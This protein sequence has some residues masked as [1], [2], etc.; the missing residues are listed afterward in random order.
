MTPIQFVFDAIGT[1]WAI[2]ILTPLSIN[3]QSITL[4]KI[5]NRIEIF[6][7]TYSRFRDDSLI[8]EISIE[9][10]AYGFPKDA[11]E[12]FSFY[13]KMY[14]ISDG[15]VTPLIGKTLSDA[16]YDTD[17]SL[18]PKNIHKPPKW[19]DVLSYNHPVL[20]VK[21]PVLL[22]F[23]AA[24]KGYIIDIVAK[25]LERAKIY[26][27][28]ID[29]GGDILLRNSDSQSLRVGLEHPM[30]PKKV[31]GTVTIK[32]QS[33][34]GSSGNR[35]N[36]G[37]YHHIINPYTLSSPKNIL[38]TWTIADSAILADGMTTCL[39][40]ISGNVLQS[41]FD[42]EYF[43]LF[44]DYSYEKSS[45]FSAEVYTNVGVIAN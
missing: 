19:G 12:L 13:K 22:D 28:C 10:G 9:K 40:F 30:N 42:F 36:W 16:G 7:K 26:D 38:S 5:K 43:V 4:K 3:E 8:T 24:G 25:I 39:F 45:N 1:L 11:E 21:K 2:D 18:M 17:Y 14:D 32:N 29:A 35:R 6:D 31:I 20:K 37:R 23:G 27:F 44:D 33:L 15:A 34:C 41:H